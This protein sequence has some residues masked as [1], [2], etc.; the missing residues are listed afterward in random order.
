MNACQLSRDMGKQSAI[1][2]VYA[3][4]FVPI[5]VFG[6]QKETIQEDK[7]FTHQ[8]IIMLVMSYRKIVHKLALLSV[9]IVPERIIDTC[10]G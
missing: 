3:I 5:N 7:S 4:N 8:S 6:C 10:Y 1:Y 9:C 2:M